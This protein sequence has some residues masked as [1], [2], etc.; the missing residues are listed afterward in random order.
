MYPAVLES[1]LIIHANTD[2]ERKN[3]KSVAYGYAS[4]I[5]DFDF[6]I[7]LV[8]L[9]NCLGYLR[10]TTRQLQCAHIDIIQGL[11]EISISK[12]YLQTARTVID[13]YSNRWFAEAECIANQVGAAVDFPR[14]SVIQTKRSNGPANTA[15]KYYKRNAAIFFLDHLLSEISV[16]FSDKH[17]I[18]YRAISIIPAVM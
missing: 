8:L 14:I 18:A 2:K 4:V 12:K 16:R 5:R 15:D 17:A 9:N 6:I 1:L 10:S 7:V 11:K 13:S 3:S